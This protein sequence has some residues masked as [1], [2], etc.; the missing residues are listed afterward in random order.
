MN[1]REFLLT[2]ALGAAANGRSAEVMEQA[3]RLHL[4]L[5]T[6]RSWLQ[7]GKTVGVREAPTHFGTVSYHIESDVTRRT[8]RAEVHPPRRRTAQG[9]VLHLRHPER[10]AMK[11]ATI[12]GRATGDFDGENEWVRLP[13]E[14]PLR[15][16]ATYGV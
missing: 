3:E 12:N 6:A 4:G 1:R 2:T 10:A 11:G 16:V 9:I 13:Q 15:M 8:I 14:G 7:Q 5:G